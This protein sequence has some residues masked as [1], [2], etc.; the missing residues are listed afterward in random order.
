MKKHTKSNKSERP[1]PGPQYRN[2][3]YFLMAVATIWTTLVF[4]TEGYAAIGKVKNVGEIAHNLHL[5]DSNSGTTPEFQA[6]E[7]PVL[8]SQL[9]G[10]CEQTEGHKQMNGSCQTSCPASGGTLLAN[11]VWSLPAHALRTTKFALFLVAT[12]NSLLHQRLNRPPIT[13]C[14]A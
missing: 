4:A 1:S 12:P 5:E 2:F 6:L 10:C 14:W 3:V 9:S 11:R 8:L 7:Q 13:S